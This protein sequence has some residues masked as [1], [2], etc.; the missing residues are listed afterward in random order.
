MNLGMGFSDLPASFMRAHLLL[1]ADPVS[2]GKKKPR[3]VNLC[4]LRF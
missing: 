3:H 2:E 4:G 1:V